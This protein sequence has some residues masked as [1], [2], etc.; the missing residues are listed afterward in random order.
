MGTRSQRRSPFLQMLAIE[1]L[2]VFFSP[3]ASEKY[4]HMFGVKSW[5]GAVWIHDLVMADSQ[6]DE[7]GLRLHSLQLLCCN[8][9]T[10]IRHLI[11]TR[12]CGYMGLLGKIS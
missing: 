9:L 2:F 6:F 10:F 5:S 7:V 4:I 11:L 3:H 12:E 8:G 1:L